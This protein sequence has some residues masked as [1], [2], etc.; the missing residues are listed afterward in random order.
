ML[1]VFCGCTVKATSVKEL[2]AIEKMKWR[3]VQNSGGEMYEI[4]ATLPVMTV[5]FLPFF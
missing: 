1:A 5:F 3:T 2:A 4:K